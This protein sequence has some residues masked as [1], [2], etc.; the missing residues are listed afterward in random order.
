LSRDCFYIGALG[1]K[2]THARRV[3]RL[4]AQGMSDADIARIHAPIGLKIG[5]TSPMEIAVAIMAQIT[6]RLRVEAEAGE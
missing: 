3:E 1:S 2:K 5:A 6:E 4:K